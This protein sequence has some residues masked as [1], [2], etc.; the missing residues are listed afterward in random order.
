MTVICIVAFLLQADGHNGLDSL[1][2]HPLG[3]GIV[4]LKM[5]LRRVSVLEAAERM[6]GLSPS[7]AQV[8]TN[9]SDM[10]YYVCFYLFSH[11]DVYFYVN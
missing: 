1:R 8:G 5:T 7:V 6:H 4:N 11:M 9:T 2:N 10:L 3:L